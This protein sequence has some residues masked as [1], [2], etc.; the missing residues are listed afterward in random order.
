MGPEVLLAD[1]LYR[2]KNSLILQSYKSRERKEPLNGD[3][4]GVGWYTAQNSPTPCIFTSITPA[5]NNQNLRRLS[6]HVKS[7]CFF[8]H[9]RAASPGM[10]VCETNCHPFQNGP[11]LWMHNGTIEGF[12]QIKRRLRESLPDQ[13]YNTIEGTT[14]S[15]HAFAVFLNLLGDPE[16]TH[17]TNEMGQALIETVHQLERWTAETKGA[18]PSYYNFAVTDGRSVAAIRY[19]SDPAMEPASLYYSAGGKYQCFQ[20]ECQFVDCQACERSVVI[21][22]ERLNENDRDWIRVAPNHVLTVNQDLE[23]QVTLMEIER[24]GSRVETSSLYRRGRQSNDQ[25]HTR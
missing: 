22:S 15:E 3:G 1:L 6:D 7:S 24:H 5:W 13:L 23:T 11:Y 4:F 12:S 14:D 25:F 16:M 21:A 20:G 9:V 10:R 2:P 8:A 17:S 19:V 18:A